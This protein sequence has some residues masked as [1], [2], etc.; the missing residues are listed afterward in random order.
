MFRC[1]TSQLCSLNLNCAE[2]TKMLFSSPA[3]VPGCTVV[4]RE[5]VDTSQPVVD[6]Y[7]AL[8]SGEQVEKAPKC[9]TKFQLKHF[10]LQKFCETATKL[11]IC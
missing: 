10:R 8:E 1:F 11:F 2:V 6:P 9:I 7:L 4:G 3:S 5:Y